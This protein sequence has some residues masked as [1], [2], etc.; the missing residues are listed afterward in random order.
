MTSGNAKRPSRST[1][2]TQT[3][4]GLLTLTSCPSRWVN[5]LVTP[6]P[7]RPPWP[8]HP[9]P[10]GQRP[11]AGVHLA[12]E[13]RWLRARLRH[14]VRHAVRRPPHACHLWDRSAPR[15]GA[16]RRQGS[17]A[18]QDGRQTHVRRRI[19]FIVSYTLIVS[20]TIIIFCIFIII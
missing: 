13:A 12:A 10:A 11:P 9:P 1:Q 14:G 20:F 15:L 18:L 4:Q 17:L 6:P 2:L 7:H 16:A 5:A 19:L 3:E 8:M